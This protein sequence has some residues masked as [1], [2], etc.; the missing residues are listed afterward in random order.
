MS[1]QYSGISIGTLSA[2]ATAV[3][4]NFQYTKQFTPDEIVEMKDELSTVI[5]NLS[6]MEEEKKQIV[7]ELK[8]K[9]KPQKAKQTELLTNIKYKSRLVSEKV[10]LIPDFDRRMMDYVNGEGEVVSS[11]RLTKEENQFRLPLASNE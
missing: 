2:N 1:N 8:E 11:R 9:M 10:Y 4:E 7:D 6:E 5:I 3:E